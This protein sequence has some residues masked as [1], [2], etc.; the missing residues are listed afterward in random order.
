M[1]SNPI[2]ITSVGSFGHKERIFILNYSLIDHCNN[3]NYDCIDLAKKLKGKF[4]YWRDD[5]HTTQDGSKVI[6][7]LIMDDLIYF[8][9]K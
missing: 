5:G 3:K 6:A 4:N 2:F 7:D 1:N 8:I 9:K